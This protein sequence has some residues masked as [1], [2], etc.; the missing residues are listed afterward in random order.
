VTVAV[1]AGALP[2]R[3]IAYAGIV[4]RAVA[5]AMDVA[6]VQT[7][8][9]LIGVVVALIIGAFS[10]FNL[11]GDV[12]T[13]LGAATAW[14]LAFG[15]YCTAFWS[16][17]GQTPGMRALGIEVTD[18]EGARLRTR[19]SIVRLVGMAL[20]AIPLFLGYLPILLRDDRRGLHDLM[21]GSVVSY[22]EKKRPPRPLRGGV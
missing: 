6:I 18:A 16:L 22:A 5:F 13:I 1:E 12:E 20:A 14:I 4:T 8:L 19:R 3:P 15:I 21:A 11:D 17:T 2:A 10:N 9:F 7:I